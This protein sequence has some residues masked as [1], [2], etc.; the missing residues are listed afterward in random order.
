MSG[1]WHPLVPYARALADAG[2]EVAFAT[3]REYCATISANGFRCFPAGAGETVEENRA[4]SERLA[5]LPGTERAATMWAEYF[6]GM[7]AQRALP[8]LLAIVREWRPDVL[9]RDMT[10]FAGWAA[11]ERLGIPHA[12]VQVAAYRSHLHA[13]I[14]PSLDRLR[15]AAGL[16]PAPPDDTLYPYLLVCPAPGSYQDPADPLPPTAHSISHGGFDALADDRLPEWVEQLPDVPI[17]YATLGTVMNHNTQILQAILDGLRDEPVNLILTTG[18]DL[19]PAVFGEQPAHIHIERYIPQSLLF[20]YCDLVIVHGGSGTVRDALRHGLPMVIV[21]VAA[22]QHANAKRCA[23][24]GLAVVISPDRRTP[25]AIREAAR[26]VL[27]QPSYRQ[28]AARMQAEMR[29]LPGPEHIVALLERLAR[30]RAPLIFR[31]PEP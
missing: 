9:V 17:V 7:W 18:R 28:S 10:E 14:A 3:A 19:D 4:R 2:H 27:Q 12:A 1:H 30:E 13:A 24:L 25:Q 16:P 20:P 29:A 22:D 11:A 31:P 8:D 5:P 26:E 23:E 15:A 21:P 6:A